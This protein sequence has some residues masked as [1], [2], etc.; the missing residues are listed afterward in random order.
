MTRKGNQASSWDAVKHA[1]TLDGDASRL[2]DYY[3]EWADRYDNDVRNEQYSGP[4]YIAE[5]VQRLPANDDTAVDPENPDIAILDAGCGTGLVGKELAQ[6]GYR[7]IDGFDISQEM[8]EKADKTQAYRALRGDV[9]L[10][11][12]IDGYPDDRYD[13]TVACGVFTLGHVPP[14]S[15]LELVRVT[16]KNGVIVV[17]TRNS[18]CE[19]SG[20]DAFCEKLQ[21]ENKVK[22]LHHVPDGPYIAEEGAQYWVF[23]VT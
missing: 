12:R 7:R 10:T 13:V 11:R 23:A 8:T 16:K 17:S 22:L 20:F 18:Y 4:A 14:E 19:N 5:L 15:L 21:E 9:D 1:H 6:R 3:R 2:K